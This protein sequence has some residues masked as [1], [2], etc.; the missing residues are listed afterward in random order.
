MHRVDHVGRAPAVRAVAE[1]RHARARDAHTRAV[2]IANAVVHER[3]VGVGV[4]ALVDAPK[5]A[6][7][8]RRRPP[9]PARRKWSAKPASGPMDLIGVVGLLGLVW[10]GLVLVSFWFGLGWVGLD[11]IELLSSPP[12]S[13]AS[14]AGAKPVGTS[15]PGTRKPLTQPCAVECMLATLPSKR[16]NCHDRSA[17][18]SSGAVE[19]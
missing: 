5:P 14:A 12:R 7:R 18:G 3:H 17:R 9:I 1:A 16:S 6:A 10:V 19:S 11:W 2:A 4:R 8:A 13:Y 15:E